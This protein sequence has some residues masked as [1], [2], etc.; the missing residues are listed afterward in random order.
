MKLLF[1]TALSFVAALTAFAR[2][3]FD[4]RRYLRRLTALEREIAE[5]KRALEKRGELANEI[6]HEIKN[7]LTAILCSAETL[8]LILGPKLEEDHRRS[9]RYIREFGDNILRLVSDFLDVS[10][11]ESGKLKATPE[12]TAVMPT[13][14][15]II[16]LLDGGMISK[17]LEFRY[18]AICENTTALVDPR[19][20]KQILF[21]LL[22]N[23]IKFTPNG[24]KIEILV[25]SDF[26]RP[27]LSIKVQDN[28][29][30]IPADEL[31]SIFDPYTRSREAERQGTSGVGLGLPLCKALA[32][33]AG[34]EIR[35]ESRE[36]LGSSFEVLLPEY[37]ANR[38]EVALRQEQG[39]A[40]RPLQGQRF[41]LVDGNEATR[42]SVAALLKAW[43]G[44]V[45][46]VAQA[47]QAVDALSSQRYDVVMVDQSAEGLPPAEVSKLVRAKCPERSTAVIVA[48]D[49][50]ESGTE[51]PA[52]GPDLTIEKPLN[53]KAILKAISAAQR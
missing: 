4:H 38:E 46:A 22:H 5:A 8:D 7:P 31:P 11:A 34:G 16:G 29:I 18:H 12:P 6:A 37:V 27:Y 10:R 26:P 39:A 47:Q 1:L 13:I 35:V 25:R 2:A 40:E 43:G 45:D 14:E 28:G 17:K 42:D 36:G 44:M 41:L 20:L 9:L 53:G 33:L 30:G 48:S 50:C 24:G 32:E 3:F 23:A 15:S 51:L 49:R 21:N 19:H 52:S